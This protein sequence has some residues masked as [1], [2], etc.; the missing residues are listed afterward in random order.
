VFTAAIGFVAGLRRDA[1]V[2][3]MFAGYAGVALLVVGMNTGNMGTLV[4]HRAFALPYIGALSALGVTVL[5]SRFGARE[6]RQTW[7]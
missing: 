4:R 1:L 2:T 7:H 3:C 6:T 5:L